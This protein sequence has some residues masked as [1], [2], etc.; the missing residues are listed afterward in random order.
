MCTVPDVYCTVCLLYRM[1]TVP[2]VYCT[3]CVLY[4]MCTVPYVYCTGCV[5]YRMC[6]VP[7]VYCTGCVLYRMCTV[8]DV[9]CTV[10]VLYRMFK[11]LYMI[12]VPQMYYLYCGVEGGDLSYEQCSSI[13][14]RVRLP[15]RPRSYKVQEYSSTAV[16]QYSIRFFK[17]RKIDKKILTDHLGNYIEC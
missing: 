13:K 6:T 10:C 17:P 5:L 15:S 8:P 12:A 11:T 3:V 16:Q 14:G 9:Y 4:R 2:Y 1:C 7:D